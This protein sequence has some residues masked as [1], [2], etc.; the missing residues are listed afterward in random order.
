MPRDA[1][2]P[3]PPPSP[4]PSPDRRG[5]GGGGGGGGGAPPPPPLGEDRQVLDRVRVAVDAAGQGAA[6]VEELQ[7][8]EGDLLVLAADADDR[9]AAAA[10]GGLPGGADR[11]GAADA[12][13]GHVDAL[14]ARQLPDLLRHGPGGDDVLGGS[15]RPC[16]RLLLRGDVDRDDRRRA[17]DPGGLEG[18]EAHPADAEHGD[19]LAFPDPGGV[20]DRAPSGEGGAAEERGVGERHAVRDGQDAVRGDDRL[21]GEGGDV[22]SGV[23]LGAVRRARVDV[24]GAGQG[25]GA[26]PDLAER[27][28]VAGAAGR[29]PVEDDAVAGG[30][31]RDPVADGDDRAGALVAEDGRD[32]HAH[33]AVGERQVGVADPG[34]G[35]PD[36]DLAGTGLGE[37]DAGDLQ[38][39]ADGGQDGGADH[40]R[41]SFGLRTGGT[42]S[43]GTRRVR[44]RR[45]PGPRRT[46]CIRRRGP[47][48]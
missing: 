1:P 20:V 29:R 6:P 21:L 25:V 11:D 28:G 8:V 27:A 15:R 43:G 35:E 4:S 40:V 12:F 45:V 37:F 47:A 36:P 24:R 30:H 38:G 3:P 48:G 22:E 31:V 44:A 42:W 9:G 34:G 10:P 13:D 16:Q 39:R 17:R 23:E 2:P 32:R 7:G 5:G 18:G 26:E 41:C 46:A 19:G 33:G 14:A